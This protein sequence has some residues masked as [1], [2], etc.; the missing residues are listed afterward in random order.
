MAMRAHTSPMA[1]RCMIGAA[2]V[3]LTAAT[4]CGGGDG[5][6]DAAA[7]ASCKP[8]SGKVTLQ[9]WSWVPGMQEAVDL[10]NGQ[11]PDVQVKL[12]TTPC[13]TTRAPTRTCP[14]P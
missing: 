2:V 5:G 7:D 10:W 13:R 3:A 8:S 14:T 4:G 12:K 6:D 11:N 9:Y 1:R